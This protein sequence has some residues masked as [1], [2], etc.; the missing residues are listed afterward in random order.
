MSDIVKKA[1]SK[2]GKT[3]LRIVHDEDVENPREWDN[4]G[5]MVCFH[6]RYNLGDKNN[7]YNSS[8]YGSWDEMEEAICKREDVALIL[9][10]Y[11]YDHSGIT[12]NTTGFSCPWDSGQ[13]G[14]IFVSKKKA[15]K[16]YGRLTKKVME[17]LR[18]Y[19]LGEVETYDQYLRGDVYGFQLVEVDEDGEEIDTIDSCYGFFG[20][21][22]KDNGMMEHVGD[23]HKG[24]FA[25][26]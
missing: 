3:E 17:K 14:F 15:R 6:K 21:N 11:L 5:T 13:V 26:L 19:L 20:D 10:L 23:E 4:I 12:I 2:D 9:P 25:A 8:D 18:K 16:E 1:T 7:D 22:W 24:L